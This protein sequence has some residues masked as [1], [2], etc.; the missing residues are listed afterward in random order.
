MDKM[1]FTATA[2]GFDP[3][4]LPE[5]EP[6]SGLWARIEAAQRAE[7]RVR[8]WRTGGWV[9]AAA[10]LAGV[11]VLLLPRASPS[12]SQD[13]V[14]GQRESQVLESEWQQLASGGRTGT[15]GTTQLRVIDDALQAAYD[16]GAAADELARLWQERNQALRGLIAGFQ[17]SGTRDMLAITRI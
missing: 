8:R 6:D 11:A 12:L 10:M 15:G 5:F 13:A 16:R 9:A 2:C 1:H 17:R 7:Q 4:Q 3:R 14:V